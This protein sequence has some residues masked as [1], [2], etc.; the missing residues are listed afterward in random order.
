MLEGKFQ[1]SKGVGLS[2]QVRVGKTSFTKVS[3]ALALSVNKEDL[4]LM[5]S[6]VLEIEPDKVKLSFEFELQM[7]FKGGI[8]IKGDPK[9]LPG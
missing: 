4:R 3:L 5:L 1:Y 2:F 7:R 9:K 6:L 8:W